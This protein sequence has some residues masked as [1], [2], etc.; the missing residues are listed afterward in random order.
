MQRPVGP[1]CNTGI[2]H[3]MAEQTTSTALPCMP[4]IFQGRDGVSGIRDQKNG[5]ERGDHPGATQQGGRFPFQ[6]FL[7]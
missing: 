3:R 5:I 2:P 7:Y 4:P 1:R 6:H